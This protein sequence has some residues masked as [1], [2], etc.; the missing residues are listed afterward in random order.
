MAD[1]SRPPARP[2]S[3]PASPQARP[4]ASGPAVVTIRALDL[5][6]IRDGMGDEWSR[7]SQQIHTTLQ[8]DLKQLLS[9]K[10]WFWPQADNFYLLVF[11]SSGSARSRW[12]RSSAAG[13]APC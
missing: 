2:A 8:K 6:K 1:P 11:W 7:R 10:G 5:S 3:E 12:S 9:G 4:A 13:S